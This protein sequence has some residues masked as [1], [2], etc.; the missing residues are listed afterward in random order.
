MA[1]KTPKK[2]MPKQVETF[3]HDEASRKNIPTAEYQ[4]VMHKEEQKA[5]HIA[6]ENTVQWMSK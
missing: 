6:G 4:S 2:K 5:L 1:K 3:T